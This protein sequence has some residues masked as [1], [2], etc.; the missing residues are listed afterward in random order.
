MAVDSRGKRIKGPVPSTERGRTI[1]A[2]LEALES[3]TVEEL[4]QH[5]EVM[6]GMDSFHQ[7]DR[8]VVP[9]RI[10]EDLA[11]GPNGHRWKC[12]VCLAFG[13]D[14]YKQE[15]VWDLD[16]PL[17]RV[18]CYHEVPRIHCRFKDQEYFGPR[19]NEIYER[20]IETYRT[21]GWTGEAPE[22]DA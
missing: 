2:H 12:G 13:E 22:P 21:A 16:S 18:F 4:A 11:R 14:W 3:M 20:C 5:V 1:L 15:E 8:L 17:Y 10:V 19:A 9:K 7:G 6:R